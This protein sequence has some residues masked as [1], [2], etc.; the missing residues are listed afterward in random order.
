MPG[1]LDRPAGWILEAKR[2]AAL[3]GAGISVD[4][5]IP[6]FR[7]PGGLWARFDP[8]EYATLDCFL[9]DPDKAWRLYRELGA[10]IEG[11]QPNPAHEALARLESIGRLRGIITQNIDGLHQ[12]A[13]SRTVIEIHGNG[14]H[15][16][17]PACSHRRPHVAEDAGDE[18]PRCPDCD[19]PLKPDV[20]LFGEAVRRLED[21]RAVTRGCDVLLVIGT[22]AQVVPASYFPSEVHRHGGRL[23]ELNL[24]RELPVDPGDGRH[25]WVGGSVSRSLPELVARVEALGDSP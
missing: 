18:V 13:G 15:L 20:V 5:G 14:S 7:S 2:V 4:S 8:A 17:C 22:S 16:H 6:D 3:T 21:A 25:A 1:D 23:I 19:H 12:A 24:R 10:S 11:K 9:G